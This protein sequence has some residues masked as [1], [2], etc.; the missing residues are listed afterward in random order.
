MVEIVINKDKCDACGE[1]VDVCPSGVYEI[2]D[3]KA[4]PVNIEDCVECCAC[5]D[6]CPNEAIEHSSC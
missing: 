1:C 4:E 2:K 3:D 5:I 6:V